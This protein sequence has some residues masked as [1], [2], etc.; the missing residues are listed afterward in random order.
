MW[1]SMRYAKIIMSNI[2]NK[3]IDLILGIRL[4]EY[5]IILMTLS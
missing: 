2:N 1:I 4:S 5:S 3:I